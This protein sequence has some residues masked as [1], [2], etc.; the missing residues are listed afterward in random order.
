M[1]EFS[2]TPDVETPE[3]DSSEFSFTPDENQETAKINVKNYNGT[4]LVGEPGED[5]KP[6]NKMD[7]FLKNLFTFDVKSGEEV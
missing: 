3:I 7:L 5:A 4:S 6:Y 2:F 1:A